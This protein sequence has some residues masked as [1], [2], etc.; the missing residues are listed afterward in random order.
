MAVGEHRAIYPDVANMMMLKVGTGVGSGLIASGK[1]HRGADG[2]AGDIGHIHLR[3]PVGHP[4]DY[5]GGA[6]LPMPQHRLRRGLRRRLGHGTRP[7][8]RRQGR[9]NRQRRRAVPQKSAT[10]PPNNYSGGPDASSVSP[11]PTRSACSTPASSR[12][13]AS[14]P[15]PRSTCSPA[16]AK[17]S[18]N[19]HY[20]SP[21]ASPNRSQPTRPRAPDYLV[22]PCCCSKRSSRS[23]ASTP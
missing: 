7:A 23:N 4:E 11:S 10:P 16:S 21:P 9:R 22:C 15:A 3:L 18:T 5:R 8:R 2:A 19:G 1:V 12:S 17:S 14:S 6:D 13:A 20:R